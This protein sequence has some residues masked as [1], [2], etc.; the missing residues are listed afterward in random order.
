MQIGEITSP[1]EL[2]SARTDWEQVYESDPEAQFFLSWTWIE[3]WVRGLRGQW[4][5][6]VARPD[7]T[8]RPVAFFP[9]RRRVRTADNGR[10]DRQ[11]VMAGNNGADYTG[12]ICIPR[13]EHSAVRAFGRHLTNR[14][15]DSLHLKNL[16]ASS[17]RLDLLLSRF[18]PRA[19][20]IARVR[21]FN[22]ADSVDNLVCP[23]LPLPA[24][25][26]VYLG[27]L[28]NSMRQKARRFLRKID[29]G[30]DG[31]RISY[32]T[33]DSFD[34]DLEILLRFWT[35]RWGA[36]KGE[37]AESIKDNFRG[38]LRHCFDQGALLLPVLWREEQPLGALA[39]LVDRR[40][41]AQLFLVGGCDTTL[42]NPPPGIVL[43]LHSIRRAI[44]DG[45]AVY[46]F[47]R[48]D[49]PYKLALGAEPQS[50]RHIVVRARA[51]VS[52]DAGTEKGLSAQRIATTAPIF[53]T[54]FEHAT[55]Q[56]QLQ[57]DLPAARRSSS[58]I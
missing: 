47:L 18:S 41:S 24:D 9:L 38:M 56:A 23:R 13:H 12:L 22:D 57:P 54:P 20:E 35:A 45:F 32:A 11:L 33:E 53:G 3:R 2:A 50:I 10:I 34:A 58:L 7:L 42:N 28:G 8:S 48:G 4:V 43:H 21:E 14:N 25:W 17:R 46:D 16:R 55:R 39:L 26:Q 19:Y 6:L 37:N 44:G 1:A 31:L 15:W 49:E 5:V 52:A 29:A 30:T 36:S 51:N 40:K 27:S